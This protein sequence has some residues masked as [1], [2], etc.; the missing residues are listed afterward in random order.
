MKHGQAK[1]AAT[2]NRSS[3]RTSSAG[4]CTFTEKG[5]DGTSAG[6]KANV[7]TPFAGLWTLTLNGNNPTIAWKGGDLTA[8]AKT[9]KFAGIIDAWDA[10]Q[11]HATIESQMCD[12]STL[13]KDVQLIMDKLCSTKRKKT[14]ANTSQHWCSWQRKSH[15]KPQKKAKTRHRTKAARSRAT[16]HRGRK[17]RRNS[18][19]PKTQ[20]RERNTAGH[21]R[22]RQE[23]SGALE[24]RTL[25]GSDRGACKKGRVRRRHASAMA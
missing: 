1:V 2:E 23:R 3:T 21:A 17:T 20:Q 8:T 16:K 4:E 5:T 10:L 12:T 15:N 9:T 25:C 14:S 18:A 11:A 7:H 19:Q 6:L 22:A 24:G 13:S